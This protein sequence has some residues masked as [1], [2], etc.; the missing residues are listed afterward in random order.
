MRNRGDGDAGATTLRY[1]RSADDVISASDPRV[2]TEALAGLAPSRSV[3]GSVT[4]TAPAD[5]G[6]YYYGACV[7]A[8]AEESDTSNNCSS[9]VR[10]TVAEP[11]KYPDLVVEAPSVDAGEPVAGTAFTL[12]AT[13]R[14]RGG[15]DAAAT[16]LRY[17]RSADDVISASDTQVGTDAVAALGGSESGGQS[18]T[19]TSPADAGTYYY[20]ACVD[21]VAEESDTANNCSSAVRVTVAEPQKYPDL[22]VE[23]PS[24][25][26]GEPVAGTAFTL[27][28]T[29]R[30]RGDGDAGAT[31]LRYHRSADDVISASDPQVGTDAVA[32]LG[33]SE[34]GAESVTLT[35]PADAGTHYYGACV[36]AVPEESDTANN[37]SSAVRVAVRDGP[38]YG[39]IGASHYN[40]YP[41]CPNSPRIGIAVD[42]NS[43]LEAR[44][45]AIRACVEAG[46][47]RGVCEVSA[48]VT[49]FSGQ[50]CAAV[51]FAHDRDPD[52][53]SC[54]F[55]YRTGPSKAAAEGLALALC[56]SPRP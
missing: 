37:C 52:P 15:G 22:V 29:V 11:K 49:V 54:W 39:A 5:A 12:S 3:D 16:T 9:A 24:V 50:E 38:K 42:K 4:L 21:A 13:V 27:S 28:A 32:A 31:T 23:A 8:V 48:R 17:H 2:G 26:A 1:H 19:L 45:S 20:G 10:V 35:A 14:N 55:R 36:D 34:S 6:T 7:D 41:V 33:G 40:G 44:E 18:V 56:P 51:I 30:N 53:D 43:E 47:I 46:G 25:D